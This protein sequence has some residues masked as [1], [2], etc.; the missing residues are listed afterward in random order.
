M[1]Q[2]PATATPAPPTA[3]GIPA[4]PAAAAPTV[5]VTT[6]TSPV[7]LQGLPTSA[8]EVQGLRERREILRDQLTRASNRREG[9]VQEL[10]SQTYQRAGPEVRLGM[11]QRLNALDARIL[12]IEQE[13]ALTERLLSNA[14]PSVLASTVERPAPIIR[15]DQGVEPAAV[16]GSFGLGVLLT[17]LIGRMR[18][19]RAYGRPGGVASAAL[20]EDPRL[21]RLTYA[22]DAI[23]EEVER[24]GEGQRFVTQ[25]LAGRNGAA[26]LNAESERR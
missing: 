8:V 4:P 20:P 24:I 15:V 12:E 22:V 10:G 2:S 26:A 13:Q 19:R 11:E 17:V 3:Q 21:D 7:P 6:P 9:V 5:T 25:L 14:D 16:F 1:P 18:R 23:A